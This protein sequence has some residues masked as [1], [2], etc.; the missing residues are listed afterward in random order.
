MCYAGK[1]RK[2]MSE[3]W[4]HESEEVEF[5]IKCR[6]PRRWARPFICML[7]YMEDCGRQGHSTNVGL[8]ADGD[9]DFRPSFL[10]Q[11]FEKF[12]PQPPRMYEWDTGDA[13]F[14]SDVTAETMRLYSRK[15]NRDK[16]LQDDD[17]RRCR[18]WLKSWSRS[19]LGAP[20]EDDENQN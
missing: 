14:D 5:T 20:W 2:P 16:W 6:M 12:Q 17:A 11:G 10:I 7:N 4:K 8:F 15:E 3:D 1:R 13:M 19:I 9:G 18:K